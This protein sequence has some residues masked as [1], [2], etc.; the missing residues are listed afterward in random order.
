MTSGIYNRNT[1][2]LSEIQRDDLIYLAAMYESKGKIYTRGKNSRRLV[3]NIRNK[4]QAQY[5]SGLLNSK[6]TLLKMSMHPK[7]VYYS[8]TLTGKK[9]QDLMILLKPYFKGD[10]FQI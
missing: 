5:V 7:N 9:I 6:V 1:P 10:G 2:P 8:I 3:L 4:K